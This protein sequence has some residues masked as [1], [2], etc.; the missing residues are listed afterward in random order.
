MA[1]QPNRTEISCHRGRSGDSV[2][3]R[4]IEL[5]VCFYAAL[6]DHL[7]AVQADCPG[8]VLKQF[9]ERGPFP[10][11]VLRDRDEGEVAGHLPGKAM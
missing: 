6:G 8:Q 7:G 2:C 1:Q 10:P 9:T 3:H 5:T 11:G 4:P